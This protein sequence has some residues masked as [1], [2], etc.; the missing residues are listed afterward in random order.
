METLTFTAT[1]YTGFQHVDIATQTISGATLELMDSRSEWRLPRS[2]A[3]N[4][5]E[6]TRTLVD[7][8][9]QLMRAEVQ[10]QYPEGQHDVITDAIRTTVDLLLLV[11]SHPA[12]AW[13]AVAR[14]S[15]LASN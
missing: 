2:D 12:A 13:S 14:T 10:G 3:M 15:N 1:A 4:G 11:T 5:T 9:D 8:L 7:K 6:L